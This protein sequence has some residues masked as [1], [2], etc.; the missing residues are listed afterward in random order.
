MAK[1]ELETVSVSIDEITPHPKN[2]RQGDIGAISESLKAHGQYRAIV[3][4]RSTGHILAG[5]HT[6]KAAKSLGWKKISAHFIDCDD[7][8]AMRILL[9]DNRANDLAT[10]DHAALAELLKELVATDDG[11][12]GTLF[13]GDDIDQL[14]YDMEQSTINNEIV[15][16]YSQ[17]V[18]IPH[19]FIVGEQPA[20]TELYDNTHT[21]KLQGRIHQTEMPDDV[22]QFLL[23]ASQRHTVFD[24]HKIAEFYPH[25]TPEI[26]QLME[27]SALVII[28]SED[29]IA[30]GYAKFAKTMQELTHRDDND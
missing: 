30:N 25:T 16:D 6:Y 4:Q 17:A 21:Q 13:D 11:L 12:A 20:P 9:A 14:L 23:L 15:S 3:V 29:A 1:K 2:V 22:R 5:N 10:Y 27:E 24:Y 8:K 28:D 26:Q 7:E 19:Y 18:K